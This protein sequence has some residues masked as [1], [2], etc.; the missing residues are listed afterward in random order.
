MVDSGK[1][2]G[3][4]IKVFLREKRLF[5][6][7]W[8]V[9]EVAERYPPLFLFEEGF[10]SAL[11]GSRVDEVLFPSLSIGKALTNILNSKANSGP[12]RAVFSGGGKLHGLIQQKTHSWFLRSG[13][14]VSCDARH[15]LRGRS[16]TVE[17][18]EEGKQER[19]DL[20]QIKI[21]RLVEKTS[22][23]VLNHTSAKKYVFSQ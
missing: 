9:G 19:R 21:K 1:N 20:R 5:P 17:G 7:F 2:K 16:W 13:T 10:I 18:K 15:L 11:K 14:M 23:N 6:S 22:K 12:Y 8:L 3:D 4:N